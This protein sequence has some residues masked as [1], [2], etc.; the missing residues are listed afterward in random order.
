MLLA[1]CSVKPGLISTNTTSGS[2]PGAAFKGRVHGGQSPISGAHVYFYGVNTTGYAGPGETASSS[3]A[4]VSLLGSASNT[5]MD[6]SG[7]YYVTTDSGGN[8][9]VSVA[10]DYTCN[11]AYPNTY[12][13]SVGGNAGSGANSA[14]TLM[15]SVGNCTTMNFANT[16]V[17]VNEVST[18]AMAYA[19]GGYIT[20]PTNISTTGALLANAGVANAFETLGNLYTQGTGIALATT[21]GTNG[22]VPQAEINTLANILA[23]C[24]NSSGSTSA[25]CTTLF[26]NAENGG[27]AAPDTATAAVNI[28]HNPGA[29]IKNLW[30]LQAG[31][32]PFVPML[33]GAPNDFTIALNYTGGGLS[34]PWGI[35]V[36]GSGDVWVANRGATSI[37]E[38]STIGAVLSG[39]TGFTGGGVDSPIGI[40]I[41]GS[42]N[43]W[44]ANYAGTS[45]SEFNSSGVEQSG[46]GYTGGGLEFPY[47]I[48]IDANNNAWIG[49]TGS[50]VSEL[51]NSGTPVSAT[52]YSG[53]GASNPYFIAIDASGNAWTAN[54]SNNTLGEFNSSGT[55]ESGSGFSGGG[56]NEPYGVAID[57]YADVWLTNRGNTSLSEFNSSGVAQSSSS[58]ITG[59][60]L[61]FPTGLAI[62]GSNNVWVT[63]DSGASISEFNH[64]RTAITGSNGYEGGSLDNPY[65]IAIDGAGNIWVSNYSGNS[66]TEFVGLATPVVT[67][68]AANLQIPYGSFTINRP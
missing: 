63:N 11:I 38:F 21:P 22:T 35:A 57:A 48:A 68:L 4:S 46:S 15:A 65:G 66:V 51:S 16:Y 33:N 26:D 52:G 14:I 41:D 2:V 64:S 8:F 55:P 29:N 45:V 56:L 61:S 32:P 59:G 60:G 44:T 1:G 53:G 20:D 34:T 50:I 54:N 27:V 43:A 39:A 62:D 42:G 28:A 25:N 49:N 5:T 36:D 58:G 12:V 19:V 67:P 31:N 10:G 7:N 37:S 9:S 17:I 40:A 6:G 3:N 30:A 23:A 47:G 18:V 24:V 13:L